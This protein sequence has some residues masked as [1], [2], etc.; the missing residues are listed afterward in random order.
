MKY[1]I[2]SIRLLLVIT[3]L[4]LLSVNIYGTDISAGNVSGIWTAVNSPYI[5]NGD[6]VVQN[7]ASLVIEPGARVL[8]SGPY[9]F[10]IK[11][12]LNCTG[13]E[14]DSVTIGSNQTGVRWNGIKLDSVD[15]ASD[16]IRFSHCRISGAQLNL[17]W[18]FNTNKVVLE[19]NTIFD[20]K[21]LYFSLIY[22]TGSNII[23]RNNS[24]YENRPQPG[25]EGTSIYVSDS[26][27]LIEGNLFRHFT[28]NYGPKFIDVWRYDAL[29]APVIRNNEFDGNN[30]SS[31]YALTV[32]SNCLPVV[33]GNNFHDFVSPYSSSAL[34]IGYVQVGAV[35]IKNNQFTNNSCQQDGGAAYVVNARVKFENNSFYGNHCESQGGA[36]YAYDESDI[37]IV[38]CTFDHNYSNGLAGAISVSN[39]LTFLVNRCL[40]QNN[41]AI[42]GGAITIGSSMAGSVTNSVFVNNTAFSNGGAVYTNQ[43]TTTQF[44]NCTFAN[45]A[46]ENGAAFYLYWNADPYFTNCIFQG[47]VASLAGDNIT[48]QDYIWNYCDP[49]FDHCIVQ[50]GTDSFVMGTSS[51]AL[52][53]NCLDMDAQFANPTSGAGNGFDASSANWNV[54]LETSPCI[55]AGT[56]TIESLTLGTQDFEGD[57]RLQGS[58]LDIGAYE[59]G[60]YISLGDFDQNG[61]VDMADLQLIIAAVGCIQNC[62]TAD[63]NG[64]GLVTVQ[65]LMLFMGYY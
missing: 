41:D 64:D 14:S 32:H 4:V 2:Q 25:Y 28:G 29:S 6:I 40:F 44:S 39:A 20:N 36:I 62:G 65:D 16:T 15:V 3:I 31:N 10:R 35:Q 63:L 52:Y 23:I 34:W 43:N 21:E 22:L 26:S 56:G 46:A 5:I 55:D 11:G 51:V 33:D 19:N 42:V 13:T 18:I 48:V 54:I 30:V 53:E 45:N 47:N 58:A 57:N 59:G 17:M 7:N 27:P 38:N 9:T 49:S 1:S 61:M 60:Y 8:F 12:N 50:D 37:E 24:F